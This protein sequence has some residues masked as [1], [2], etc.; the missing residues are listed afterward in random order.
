M[1]QAERVAQRDVFEAVLST[2][3]LCLNVKIGS[4]SLQDHVDCCWSQ[5]CA[6]RCAFGLSGKLSIDML[7]TYLH[8]RSKRTDCPLDTDRRIYMPYRPSLSMASTDD[9]GLIPHFK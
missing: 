1:V 7:T 9:I 6:L 4:L 2:Y 5:S 8:E 3:F